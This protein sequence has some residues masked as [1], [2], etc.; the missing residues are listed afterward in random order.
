VSQ[1]T[2]G[3]PG[4]QPPQY[5]PTPGEQAPGY[6]QQGPGYGQQGPGY[7]QQGPGY[8]G[9]P[10]PEMSPADQRQW[11]MLAH[12]SA[13][14]AGLLLTPLTGFGL[15]LGW[16]G[17]LVVYLVL[18]ERGL[19]VRGQALEALNFQI[20]FTAVYLA[21]VALGLVTFGFGFVITVP[22]LIAA[23]IYALIVTVI[24]AT[25]ANRGI[26]YR[27]PISWRLVR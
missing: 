17:P 20:L 10:R 1:Q 13:L 18:R 3:D 14:A 24:A 11:G 16:L 4:Q 21:G 25:K 22:L 7:G 8:G 27:Y 9:G 6:G 2:P 23:G 5:R 19:F 12:L 26:A 15:Y